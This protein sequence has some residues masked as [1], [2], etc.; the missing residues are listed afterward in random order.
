MAL[1]RSNGVCGPVIYVGSVMG[2]TVSG[3]SGGNTAAE[4]ALSA[5]VG[6]TAAHVTGDK[7]AN[8]AVTAAFAFVARTIGEMRAGEASGYEEY[9]SASGQAYG[10]QSD[11]S[12]SDYGIDYQARGGLVATLSRLGDGTYI[13]AFKGTSSIRDW[14]HNISQGLFGFSSQYSAARDLAQKSYNAFGGNVIFTGHS[15]GGGLASAAAYAA[16]GKA[17]TFNAAGLHFRNRRENSPSITAHYVSGDALTSMQRA[18]IFLPNAPGTP[19][20]HTGRFFQGPMGRHGV[21]GF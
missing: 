18:A 6:G 11:L 13:V 16:D 19:V 21:G 14:L 10:G 8:G 5:L 17:I 2:A 9:A 3:W 15:L 7:F 20:R 4:I 12:F 1:V